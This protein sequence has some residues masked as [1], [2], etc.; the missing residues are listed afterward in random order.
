MKPEA[1]SP[2]SAH[3][4]RKR[5]AVASAVPGKRLASDPLET[6]LSA[7]RKGSFLPSV[8]PTVPPHT[9]LLGTQP[10]DNSLAQGKYFMTNANA[11]WHI[12][13]GPACSKCSHPPPQKSACSLRA[14]RLGPRGEPPSRPLTTQATRSASGAASTSAAGATHPTT[15][16]VTSYIV[17]RSLT[18]RRSDAALDPTLTL[19]LYPHPNADP[20]PNL[21]ATPTLTLTSTRARIRTRALSLTRTL[22][23]TL[24]RTLT[25]T[26]ALTRRCGGSLREVMRCG[27][28]SPSRSER[29]RST[30]TS[31]TR[32]SP[33]CRRSWGA[34]P[35]SAASASHR[36]GPPP[37]SSVA[38]TRPGS[39]P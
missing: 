26:L 16:G 33:T 9:L 3:A 7:T 6:K 11:F 22:T 29:A 2:S 27:T 25:P 1:I 36:A 15:S 19:Q 28:L 37:S 32:P 8:D 31:R 34:T 12:V 39:P 30:L 17:R 18:M 24:A 38:R 14:P 35:P 5:P 4:S 20:H 23:L 13:G 10:S 21:N